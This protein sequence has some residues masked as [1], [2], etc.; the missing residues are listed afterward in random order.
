MRCLTGEPKQVSRHR[1]CQSGPQ[2]ARG[3]LAFPPQPPVLLTLVLA[4]LRD[5]RIL[6]PHHDLQAPRRSKRDSCKSIAQSAA[7][8][9]TFA[10]VRRELGDRLAARISNRLLIA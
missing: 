6:G 7:A 10:R 8:L 3:F 2:F 9:S 4:R 1:S 5:P